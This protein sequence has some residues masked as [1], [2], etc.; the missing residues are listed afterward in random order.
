MFWGACNVIGNQSVVKEATKE[1]VVK[2]DQET[3]PMV[4]MFFL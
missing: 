1:L 3:H 2:V 4:C